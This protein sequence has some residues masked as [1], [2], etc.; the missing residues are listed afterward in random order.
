MRVLLLLIFS[1]SLYS[2]ECIVDKTKTPPFMVT[3]ASEMGSKTYENFKSKDNY[4]KNQNI[5]P[6]RSIVKIKKGSEEYAKHSK[7]YVPVEIISTP[8]NDKL[9]KNL[10]NGIYKRS[11]ADTNKLKKTK[12]GQKGFL[13][14]KSLK[15]ADEFTYIVDEASPLIADN[16][17]SDQGVVAIKPIID[18]DGNFKVLKCCEPFSFPK[19]LACKMK[20]QF[21]SIFADESVG[22]NI[23][24]DVDNCAVS[25]GLTPF[26]NNDIT[27]IMNILKTGFS[28]DKEMELGDLELFDAKG[29][30]KIPLNYEKGDGKGYPGP[31]GSYHYNTDDKGASDVFAKPVAACVFTKVLELHN[32]KC[33]EPGCQV[34]FGDI[35][36]P[37]SFNVHS[38]HGG[39]ECFDVRPLK[40]RKSKRAL[41][42][43]DS[44]YDREKTK[45]LI[46]LFEKAG[47]NKV[48]F[49]DR[50]VSSPHIRRTSDQSHA[51]HMHVCF[52]GND[53]KTK[54]I[55]KN[56][57]KD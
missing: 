44:L 13:Y 36:H 42:Y 26:K 21:S 52:D 1:L 32:K 33:T 3:D 57:I 22:K 18:S 56:G 54:D 16:G 43:K 31:F 15:K 24:V 11:S 35:Y 39:G 12:I 53:E 47:A 46:D 51:N 41:N 25:S 6:R 45:G 40:K 37:R 10:K 48:I 17:L 23:F 28:D 2:Q 5:I 7:S 9:D 8:D 49:D 30:I 27:P 20:Y 55:C 29:V 50:K 19:K 38:S 14:A 34:Q 4:R